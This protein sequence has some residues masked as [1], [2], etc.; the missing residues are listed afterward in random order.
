MAT[1]AKTSAFI[2]IIAV[3]AF[4]FLLQ[5]TPRA[6]L[7]TQASGKGE[8][9]GKVID[10][11]GRPIVNVR[12]MA[13]IPGTPST[14]LPQTVTDRN[15][16]FR[17]E[18]LLPE[19]Y[20]LHTRKEDEGYPRSEFDFYHESTNDETTVRVY[21]DQVASNIVIQLQKAAFLH[22]RVIDGSS[23]KPI[24]H[25]V[26]LMAQVADPERTLQMG[27]SGGEFRAVVPAL[28]ITI[29]VSAAG[30][31]EWRYKTDRDS[32]LFLAPGT[33]HELNVVMRHSN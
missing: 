25:F 8:I 17:I 20:T 21:A 31:E 5:P 23:R 16:N 26:V 12:V 28:P 33:S 13:D 15:G 2:A 19:L 29:R 22:G 24:E 18:N 27:G 7:V 3:G 14:T 1:L 32:S 9:T 6:S 4:A 10:A 11:Q 30:Y